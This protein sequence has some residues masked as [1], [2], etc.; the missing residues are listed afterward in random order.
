MTTTDTPRAGASV[1]GS[2]SAQLLNLQAA[3]LAAAADQ[4]IHTLVSGLPACD[5]ELVRAMFGF[6][7]RR[8]RNGAELRKEFKLTNAQISGAIE[9]SLR[10]L[11]F[12]HL[13]E[14]LPA[15]GELLGE[16]RTIWPDRAWEHSGHILDGETRARY[17]QLLMVIAGTP[18]HEAET[19]VRDHLKELRAREREEEHQRLAQ[20]A[21]R[22][23][24]RRDLSRLI[25]HTIWPENPRGVRDLSGYRTM[26]KINPRNPHAG[27][28]LSKKLHRF[29]QYES[30]LER[31]VLKACETDGRII[32]Y[33]EQPI[34]LKLTID[35]RPIRYT[36]DGIALIRNE[37][38]SCPPDSRA[39]YAVLFEVKPDFQ[40]GYMENWLRWRALLATRTAVFIGSP[41]T[42]ILDFYRRAE[43][44]PLRSE[45]ADAV[46]AGPIDRQRYLQFKR[47]NDASMTDIAHAVTALQLDWRADPLRI[48]HPSPANQKAAREFWNA[49]A[50]ASIA[51]ETRPC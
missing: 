34:R 49:V 50:L 44:T 26:R 17:A 15:I 30:G 22:R 35:G 27:Y 46:A 41:R 42:S 16:D 25:D 36:P 9:R 23:R 32:A 38:L 14:E 28:F 43:E 4:E 18:R 6:D 19:R 45:L 12:A 10:S 47:D 3:A 2:I 11:W 5:R 51:L 37:G 40:C 13:I 48:T 20:E 7:G 21:A 8:V 33:Q 1:T 31:D 29:V 24:A 39:W